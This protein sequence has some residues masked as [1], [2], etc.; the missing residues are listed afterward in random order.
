MPALMEK[1]SDRRAGSPLSTYAVLGMQ[2]DMGEEH[3]QEEGVAG[4]LL[5]MGKEKG[6]CKKFDDKGRETD[7]S[8]ASRA[9]MLKKGFFSASSL[10]QPLRVEPAKR[11]LNCVLLR[12]MSIP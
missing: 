12:D 3:N 8:V 7:K 6:I 10:E 9:S 5:L 2:R 1:T 4:C 11:V